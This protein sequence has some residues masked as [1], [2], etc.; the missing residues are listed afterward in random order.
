MAV[1]QTCDL[2]ASPHNAYQDAQP[3]HGVGELGWSPPP[4]VYGHQLWRRLEYHLRGRYWKVLPRV[5]PRLDFLPE[6]QNI[7]HVSFR[8]PVLGQLTH[9]K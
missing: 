6:N 7:C 2:D 4:P 5:V 8:C 1:E 9:N 3:V